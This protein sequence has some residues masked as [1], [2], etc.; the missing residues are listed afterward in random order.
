MN[1]RQRMRASNS[2]VR[3][4]LLRH[5]FTQIWFKPHTR[6]NDVVYTHQGTY[7]ATDL[8]NLFDGICFHAHGYIVF[9][10]MKTNA[11]PKAKP[12]TDFLEKTKNLRV[13]CFNVTNKYKNS[14]GNYKVLVRCYE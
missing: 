1:N 12:I 13:L 11:W 4:W 9:L 10:Q 6:R 14:N 7:R 8:W 2:R 5:G 3:S